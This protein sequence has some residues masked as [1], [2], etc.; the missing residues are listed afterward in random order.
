MPEPF[1]YADFYGSGAVFLFSGRALFPSGN[2][3]LR[4]SALRDRRQEAATGERPMDRRGS[5]EARCEPAIPGC[6][7]TLCNRV[8]P[9]LADFSCGLAFR[10]VFQPA[11]FFFTRYR[12]DH[13]DRDHRDDQSVSDW[14]SNGPSVEVASEST[15]PRGLGSRVDRRCRYGR[16]SHRI[17]DPGRFRLVPQFADTVS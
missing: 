2:R 14:R 12:R 10:W 1:Y 4:W 6:S 3:M 13:W 9:G 5:D 7:F 17:A 8:G 16:I 15:E 11:R